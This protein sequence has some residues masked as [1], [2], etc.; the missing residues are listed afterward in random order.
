MSRSIARRIYADAFAKWPKQDL[1]PDYQLQ[2]ILKA[3]V[4][5]RYKNYNPAME[6]EETLKARAL[7]FLVQDKFNN[8]VRW[9]AT[10]QQMRLCDHISGYTL[11]ACII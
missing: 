4:E 7:Q 8:R 1:R 10:R 6:A 5:E 3:A 9:S 2:D 11:L